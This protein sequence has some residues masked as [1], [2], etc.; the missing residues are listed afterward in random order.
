L[1]LVILSVSNSAAIPQKA[2]SDEAAKDK[3]AFEAVCGKCHPT[4]MDNRAACDSLIHIDIEFID[5]S[6]AT[7]TTAHEQEEI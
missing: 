7:G 4:S 2:A 3:T 6:P 1:T 5:D